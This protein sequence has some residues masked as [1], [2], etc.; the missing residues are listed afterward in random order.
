V[1]AAAALGAAAA[2]LAYAHP[3][4]PMAPGAPLVAEKFVS[5]AGAMH[6]FLDHATGVVAFGELHQTVKT[7]GI[8]SSIARF[9]DEILPAIAPRASHLIVE[10]WIS[11]GRC[12]ET[13]KK[14]T[15]DVGRTTERPAETENEIV[16]LLRRAKELGVTPHV[17]DVDCHE[18]Q[19]LVGKGGEVDYDRLLTITG[20]HLG[21]AV[22][23]A[24]A[25]PR[26][27]D[28]PLVLVYGGALHNDLDPNPE[29]AK[30]SFGPAIDALTHGD[31]HEVD[32]FVPELVATYPALRA[33][34]WHQVWSKTRATPGATLV[35]RQ[36]RSAVLLFEDQT[37]R[38]RKY[39]KWLGRKALAI[40][41]APER[42]EAYA[43]RPWP[44][45]H[46]PASHAADP[47]PQLPPGAPS[48]LAAWPVYAVGRPLTAEFSR[49]LTGVLLDDGS[50]D[51]DHPPFGHHLI[52]GC[53][54]VPGVGYRIWSGA[55]SV[56]VVF[57]FLC[58]EVEIVWGP[59]PAGVGWEAGDI[60]NAR[61]A[62]VALAKEA[63]PDVA[64]IAAI[65]AVRPNR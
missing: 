29:L 20:Q 19:T 22:E 9:T 14:V 39:E 17:L 11:T 1:N 26:P 31:Y 49:R 53:T 34:R 56:D 60:D 58:D 44:V 43:V 40:L 15:A 57:C 25:L 5:P 54:I 6:A 45:G 32:L 7:A 21:R 48:A 38:R 65:P 12:G 33:E 51:E 64:E 46:V 59:G 55:R 47:P 30:Y 62:F 10:T 24:L 50:Y 41:E 13:E 63:L 61:A 3:P 27:P 23:Q 28:R 35:R 8:R 2:L 52:K 4:S 36:T 37:T 16:R 18:Y 42:I